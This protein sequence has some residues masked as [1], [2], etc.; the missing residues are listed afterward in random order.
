MRQPCE[1]PERLLQR[2][3]GLE[4]TFEEEEA[5]SLPD[6]LNRVRTALMPDSEL[7]LFAKNPTYASESDRLAMA[8]KRDEPGAFAAFVEFHMPLARHSSKMLIRWFGMDPDDAEQTAM[9]GLIEAARRFDPERG[10]Q[11]ST[12]AGYW[13]RQICQRYGIEWGLRIR[14]PP[15]LFW[16]C[17]RLRFTRIELIATHGAHA[18]EPLFDEALAEAGITRKQWE[19][20]ATALNVDFLSSLSRGE[21]ADLKVT[22]GAPVFDE[23]CVDEISDVIRA[24]LKY[25]LSRQADI[26]RLRYGI[27]G[28]EHTLE[29]VAAKLGVT[30][31][32]VRQLQVQAEAKLQRILQEKFLE[33]GD[34]VADTETEE[35][36]SAEVTP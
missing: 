11:F 1:P 27:D 17:F 4:V 5:T 10:F 35:Q 7:N 24:A 21:V 14:V 31:E 32:R 29:E 26:L 9:I 12:Y 16:P 18:A 36:T 33:D 23:A 6:V 15:H 25:L 13:L 19:S 3:K 30:R 8:M 28:R 20:F 34:A 2:L 22:E